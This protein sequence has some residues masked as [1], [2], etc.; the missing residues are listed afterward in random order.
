MY[1]RLTNLQTWSQ[2]VHIRLKDSTPSPTITNVE[3]EAILIQL[4]SDDLPLKKVALLGPKLM[5]AKRDK[6]YPGR[7]GQPS[8]ATAVTIFTKPVTKINFGPS[9]SI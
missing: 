8:L 9:T 2:N 4:L 6:H 7:S 5:Y 3:G 1:V